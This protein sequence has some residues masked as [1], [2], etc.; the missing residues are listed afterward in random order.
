MWDLQTQLLIKQQ[1][2]Q[3]HVNILETQQNDWNEQNKCNCDISKEYS[4]DTR[5]LEDIRETCSEDSRLLKDILANTRNISI[6]SKT[7]GWLLER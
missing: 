7:F 6:Y 3:K 5:L 4:K 2:K 1:Q